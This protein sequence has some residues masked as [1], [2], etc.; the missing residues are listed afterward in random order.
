MVIAV[1]T[2]K[3]AWFFHPDEGRLDGPILPGWRV[4]AFGDTN[5]GDVLLATASNWFGASIHRSA[6]LIDWRQIDQAPAWPEGG[7]R[8]LTQIWTFA[9]NGGHVYAGVDEAGL[10]VSDDDGTSWHPVPGIN[11]HPTRSGWHPGFGGLALHRVVVDPT[12]DNRLW[13]G[14]SAVGVFRS[15]DGGE[16]WHPVNDGVAKTAPSQDFDDIG[17]CVHGIA[18]DPEDTNRLYRQD[19][20]G[21]YRS[22]D[23]G[24]TWVRT[25][26]GLPA[27][28]GFPMVMDHSSR[29][30]YVVPLT[31]DERRLPPDG[32]FRV[33]RSTNGADRWEVSGAGH[34]DAPTFTQV[35]RGA[36]D[37]DHQG[38]VA[39]GTTSGRVGFTSDGGDSWET[40]A[41]TLPRILTVRFLPL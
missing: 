30:L 38:A 2:E 12:H 19:H 3:G 1:G 32:R 10:F 4:T 13:V 8:S 34:P 28:F 40:M 6:N 27:V 33:Y 16:S 5:T 11:E 22:T 39:F 7:D 9:R 15:D 18:I 20:Q 37:T 41:W 14:I 25:E 21:V 35:L 36:M 29:R 17:F 23:A 31:S 24:S 26:A